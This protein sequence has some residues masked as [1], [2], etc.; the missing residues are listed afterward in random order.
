MLMGIEDQAILYPPPPKKTWLEELFSGS[1]SGL[2]G[3]GDAEEQS[4]SSLVTQIKSIAAQYGLDP[5]TIVSPVINYY[6]GFT[7]PQT[8]SDHTI[9]GEVQLRDGTVALA[10]EF[11]PSP[12]NNVD[13]R[14]RNYADRAGI[15]SPIPPTPAPPVDNTNTGAN[16]G[17]GGSY[18]FAGGSGGTGQPPALTA[19]TG[20]QSQV[21]V[22]VNTVP[23]KVIDT[24]KASPAIQAQAQT[25]V[26]KGTVPAPVVGATGSTNTSNSTS[27]TPTPW[28]EN[29]SDLIG[30]AALAAAG[31][32]I[33]FFVIKGK[34]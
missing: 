1:G 3:L 11:F 5:V 30:L 26:N 8:G 12:T 17:G 20:M 15:L 19:G 33:Y 31:A 21:P 16:T 18:Y 2:S 27:T 9:S 13:A 7:N 32:G 6:A 29:S 14:M 22:N 28:Y 23:V 10:A 24:T 25:P 4:D 34:H